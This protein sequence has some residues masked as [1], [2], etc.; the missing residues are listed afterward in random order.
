[1]QY[2]RPTLDAIAKPDGTWF[3]PPQPTP[4]SAPV[5][6]SSDGITVADAD[7][8]LAAAKETGTAG[9]PTAGALLAQWL[10]A[11]MEL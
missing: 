4:D 11:K 3:V 9:G 5:V 6:L 1:M 7:V 2:E 8:L 10:I